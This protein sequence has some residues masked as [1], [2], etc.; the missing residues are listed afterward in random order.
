MEI[1]N[2]S[3]LISKKHLEYKVEDW[4]NGKENVLLITG[5][6]GGGKSTM[7]KTF[8]DKYNAV[9]VELDLFEHN[10]LLFTLNGHSVRSEK[11][12]RDGDKIIRDYFNSTYGG[13]VNWNDVPDEEFYSEFMKFFK[14]LLKYANSNKSK[15]FVFE[16]IQIAGI[17]SANLEGSVLNNLPCIVI[18]TSV[19]TSMKRRIKRDKN[20]GDSML[21]HPFKLL[22]WYLKRN[23]NIE[24][25]R[26]SAKNNLKKSTEAF[27]DFCYTEMD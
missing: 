22:K 2:E 16:G 25:F 21:E 6:S 15:K 23:K 19:F 27:I 8:Q 26:K 5:L 3:L 9:N 17:V 20:S 7:A 1:S 12:L 10:R 13:K 14:Y 18:G 24:L 11:T 4:K